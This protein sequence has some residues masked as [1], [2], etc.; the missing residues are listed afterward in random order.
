MPLRSFWSASANVSRVRAEEGL[1]QIDLLLVANANFASGETVKELREA[2]LKR[3]GEP[4][5]ADTASLRE[6]P[7]EQH[8]EGIQKLKQIFGA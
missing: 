1:E 3:M 2:F 6:P 4:A 8:S 7:P 5:K